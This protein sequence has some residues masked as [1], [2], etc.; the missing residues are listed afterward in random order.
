MHNHGWLETKTKQE[1]SKSIMKLNKDQKVQLIVISSQSNYCCQGKMYHCDSCNKSFANKSNLNRHN[2][3]KH[4]FEDGNDSSDDNIDDVYD[5]SRETRT[6]NTD[7]SDVENFS[8]DEE[9][10]ESNNGDSTNRCKLIFIYIN[11]SKIII[12][13]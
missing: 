2:M 9:E 6:E 1:K 10:E 12:K 7:M 4:P 8:S 13:I 3:A 5:H 11:N